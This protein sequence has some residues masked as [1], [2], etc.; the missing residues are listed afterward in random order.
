MERNGRWGNGYGGG[1]CIT[2]DG[3]DDEEKIKSAIVKMLLPE[4]FRAL[5]WTIGIE[6]I[7]ALCIGRWFSFSF[8]RFWWVIIVLM[9]CVSHPVAYI[10][11]GRGVTWFL[12]EAG[13]VVFEMMVVKMFFT[14]TSWRQVAAFSTA[15]N[16]TSAVL[17]LILFF[18]AIDH[19]IGILYNVDLA[20]V[21]VFPS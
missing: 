2:R 5:G 17:G 19:F 21:V 4:I 11:V 6:L 8:P 13:V 16:V 7:S 14:S 20:S 12:V 10:L 15:L 1:I 3:L 9:N 18:D